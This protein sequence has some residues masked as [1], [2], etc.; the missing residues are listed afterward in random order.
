MQIKIFTISPVDHE[1]GT[2]EMNKFLRST[3]VVEVKQEYDAQRGFWT[4]VVTYIEGSVPQQKEKSRP[5]E[6]VDYKEIL[7]SEDFE[8]FSQMRDARKKI[9]REESVPAYAIF[10]DKELA[11]MAKMEEISAE[12]MLT[13]DGIGPARVDRYSN[14]LIELAFPI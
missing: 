8:R 9:A 4:F 12:T 11:E 2:E 3:R 10:T 5:T 13:I 6:R 14:R 1:A 7:S